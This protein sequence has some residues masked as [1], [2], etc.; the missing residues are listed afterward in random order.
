MTKKRGVT[1]ADEHVVKFKAEDGK[2]VHGYLLKPKGEGQFPAIVLLHGGGSSTEATCWLG[3]GKH[4]RR[5]QGSGYVTLAVDYR[6]SELGGAEIDDV[7]AGINHLKGLPC[8]DKD[9]IGLFGSSHGAYMS[10]LTSARVRG[11]IKAVVDNFGFTNLI[12]QYED[13]VGGQV[14]S[15][16]GEQIE[17]LVEMA[18]RYFGGPPSDKNRGIYEERSPYYNIDAV[19]APVL[20]IHGKNDRSV[21]VARQTYAF[22]DAL[23]EAGK[24]CDMKIYDDGPHGFIYGNS[25]E[26]KDAL[27]ATVTFFNSCLGNRRKTNHEGT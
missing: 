6:P 3:S 17:V 25:S 1:T 10:L 23:K 2:E 4:A 20:I 13:V 24:T 19:T 5:F 9:S 14:T 26:A 7:I 15:Y 12:T 16:I 22:G 11:Q 27:E 8:V 18:R 21:P